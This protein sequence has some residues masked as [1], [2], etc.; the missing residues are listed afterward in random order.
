VTSSMPIH[1]IQALPTARSA[2]DRQVRP[3]GMR[4]ASGRVPVGRELPDAVV[5]AQ[6]LNERRAERTAE[7]VN[8]EVFT[9]FA[10]ISTRNSWRRR[11]L[12]EPRLPLL[13]TGTSLAVLHGP[14]GPTHLAIGDREIRDAVAPTW[15]VRSPWY[16]DLPD[17]LRRS[18]QLRY[19]HRRTLR[20]SATHLLS[21]ST[22]SAPKMHA[23]TKKLTDHQSPVWSYRR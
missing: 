16:P 20:Q 10:K 14:T 19:H 6:E 4:A 22:I 7:S 8:L 15:R 3:Y 11:R 12:R 5:Q 17:H 23:V 21:C 1:L 9:T 2:G 13:R 18:S